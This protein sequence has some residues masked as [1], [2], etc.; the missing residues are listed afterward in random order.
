MKTENLKDEITSIRKD[1]EPTFDKNLIETINQHDGE[2]EKLKIKIK[3]LET[4][5]KIL[6]DDIST[7]QKLIDSLL[8]HNNLLLTQQERLN[9]ELLTPTSKNSCKNRKKNVL[10]M[11]NNIRQEEIP[12]K[13]GISKANKLLLKKKSLKSNSTNRN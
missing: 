11:E 6:K 13:L 4:E 5:N 10:Q 2:N 8:Q 7:K 3:L 12:G 1:I 9:A